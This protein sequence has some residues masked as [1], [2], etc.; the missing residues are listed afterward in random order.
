MTKVDLKL[1]GRFGSGPERI[2]RTTVLTRD[3]N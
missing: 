2:M 3:K 1:M